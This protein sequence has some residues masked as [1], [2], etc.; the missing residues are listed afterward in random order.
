MENSHEFVSFH[1]SSGSPDAARNGQTKTCLTRSKSVFKQFGIAN[2]VLSMVSTQMTHLHL[3]A[4]QYSGH[5][6]PKAKCQCRR[7]RP[8]RLA[9]PP[10]NRPHNRRSNRVQHLWTRHLDK[11]VS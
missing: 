9:P 6:Q 2:E 10:G 1:S 8:T 7:H 11:L 5:S 3:K 4:S